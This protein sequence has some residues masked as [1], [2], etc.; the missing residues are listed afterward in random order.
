M[1]AAVDE[2]KTRNTSYFFETIKLLGLIVAPLIA[3]FFLIRQSLLLET[4]EG[5]EHFHLFWG[6]FTVALVGLT[7]YGFISHHVFNHIVAA[8]GLGLL[9]SF[10]KIVLFDRG[11][12]F[13]DEYAHVRTSQDIVEGLPSGFNSIVNA[14]PLF[15]GMHSIVAV[16]SNIFNIDVWTAGAGLIVGVHVLTPLLLLWF[17]KTVG[18]S[19]KAGFFA[20]LVYVSNSNWMYFHSQFAYESLGLPLAV[21]VLGLIFLVLK[22]WGDNTVRTVGFVALISGLMF[23]LSHI[24]HLSTVFILIIVLTFFIVNLISK[25]L[26]KNDNLVS[27]SIVLATVVVGSMKNVLDNINFIKEYLFSPVGSGW[28]QL[29]SLINSLLF[30]ED[31]SDSARTLFEGGVLPA[32]EVVLSF[33]SV[34][35]V[36]LIIL[37]GATALIPQWREKVGHNMMLVDK[38]SI[39]LMVFGGL[40]VVSVFLILT[41][42]GAEGARRSWGYMFIGIGLIAAWMWDSNLFKMVKT[43]NVIAV[44]LIPALFIG[45]TAAGLNGS[46][47][48]PFNNIPD[49]VI[50]DISASSVEGIALGEWFKNNA[51]PNTWV[52]AD[53]YAK[54]QIGSTGKATVLPPY[55]NVPYWE[56]YFHP[57]QIDNE[58][59]AAIAVSV[60]ASG[61]KYMVVDRRM[62]THMPEIGLWFSRTEEDR[63][64][65]ESE[66]FMTEEEFNSIENIF[67]L[68]YNT[69]VG[70]YEIYDIVFPE[71]FIAL[72]PT[73]QPLVV[74]EPK[75]VFRFLEGTSRVE[76]DLS[77]VNMK[78]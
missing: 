61:A 63:F 49:N 18:F 5:F 67:F 57:D 53:R 76:V 74:E 59:L 72:M 6:G 55:S 34:I 16:I 47:R 26:Q 45:S 1:S 19:V 29:F 48:F 77:T 14:V 35:L 50:S 33:V 3:A 75:D 12:I 68:Q 23:A 22:N 25:L 54:L 40:Y 7:I 46:Y 2:N 30:G 38:E 41:P 70:T 37:Y 27:T 32:Y 31:D 62:M 20:A 42:D 52:L 44:V 15:D 36:G 69:T 39:T 28:E 73:F 24:H 10:Y 64:K 66:M 78:G 4:S 17:T 65:T 13:H 51:Q 58:T 9:G 60:Y 21:L 11:P 56:L 43:Q 71:E 8:L